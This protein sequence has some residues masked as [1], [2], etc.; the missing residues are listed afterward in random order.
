MVEQAILHLQDSQYCYAT[1]GNAVEIMLRTGARDAF[2][3]V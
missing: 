2:E 3:A 1:G